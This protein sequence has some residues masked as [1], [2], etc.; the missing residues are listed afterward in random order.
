MQPLTLIFPEL[1]KLRQKGLLQAFQEQITVNPNHLE[2]QCV[3]ISKAK[4]KKQNIT[5]GVVLHV[6]NPSTQETEASGIRSL[7]SPQLHSNSKLSC[8][9][10]S[11]QKN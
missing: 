2:I 5:S 1:G 9:M 3:T 8:D 4:A 10:K 7:R 11:F 6:F